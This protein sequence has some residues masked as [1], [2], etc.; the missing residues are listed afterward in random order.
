MS[1][2]VKIG[3]SLSLHPEVDNLLIYSGKTDLTLDHVCGED[4]RL[5]QTAFKL[6]HYVGINQ[7]KHPLLK[8]QPS[9]NHPNRGSTLYFTD[10]SK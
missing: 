3:W 2:I 6:S 8:R 10:T 1:V 7:D 4:I 5:T 9:S